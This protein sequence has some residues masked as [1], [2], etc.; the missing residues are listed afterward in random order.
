MPV[1][2]ALGRLGQ[3][4]CCEFEATLGHRERSSQTKGNETAHKPSKCS[5]T[6]LYTQPFYKQSLLT[7]WTWACSIGRYRLYHCLSA[8]P[9]PITITKA[10]ASITLA[11][12]VSIARFDP[13]RWRDAD[14]WMRDNLTD[15]EYCPVLSIKQVLHTA[16]NRFTLI[17]IYFIPWVLSYATCT[18]I[19]PQTTKIVMGWFWRQI[20]IFQAICQLCGTGQ[21]IT[22]CGSHVKEQ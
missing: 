16:F 11:W 19:Y 13:G 1:I 9:S 5:S 15:N 14:M 22:R 3:D 17:T 18:R 21:V 20:S 6:K 8:S 4:K 2:P 10:Y 7:I 12:H